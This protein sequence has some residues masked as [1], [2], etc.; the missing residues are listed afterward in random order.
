MIVTTRLVLRA[1]V[2][3]DIAFRRAALNTPAVQRHLGGV[4]DRAAIE[5]SLARDL[6]AFTRD[7]Y[8]FWVVARRDNGETIGRCGLATIA[9]QPEAISGRAQI[10]WAFAEP[11]WGQG[12]GAEAAGAALDYA[13][14]T[15]GRGEVWGQTS[16]SNT[17]STKLMS[18]LGFVRRAD[19]DYHDV[20]FPAADNPTTIHCLAR[21]VWRAREA[22]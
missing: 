13:F 7:G 18:R 8:G 5:D 19:L 2:P 11:Y 14:E 9:K 3:G 20:D 16:A 4:A 17:A 15:L 21:R 12:Y 6:A 22:A 10:G 1:P